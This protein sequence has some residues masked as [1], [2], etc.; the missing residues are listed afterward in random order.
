MKISNLTEREERQELSWLLYLCPDC[1][2][3]RLMTI[4]AV[5]PLFTIKGSSVI[6]YQCDLCGLKEEVLID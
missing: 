3:T 1:G 6:H 2:P 5:V 4:K